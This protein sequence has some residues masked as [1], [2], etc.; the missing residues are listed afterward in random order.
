MDSEIAV[1]EAEFVELGS[2]RAA[3]PQDVVQRA[4]IIAKELKR[5]VDQCHLTSK[6]S[7]K[8]F[9]RVEAWTTVGAMIGVLPREVST[10]RHDD[11]G[12]EATVEL[13]RASDGAVIGRGSAIVGMD[14]RT[15]ASR[16]EYARRS[17]AI[18][19]ATG[20]AYRLGFSWIM[21]LA[22]YEPTPAE[23]MSDEQPA[24]KANPPAQKQEQPAAQ[25]K[26]AV[27]RPG[28]ADQVRAGLRQRA[29]W[30]K[31]Q[32][33]NWS[34][35]T[36]PPADQQRPPA[37]DDVQRLAA[38]M[39]KGGLDEDQRHSVN[40][41]L[42]GHRSTTELTAAEVEAALKAWEATDTLPDGSTR[43]LKFHA[44]EFA[45][46][47]LAACLYAALEAAGQQKLDI[48]AETKE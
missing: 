27:T 10:I 23:E 16:P 15:W 6:I 1:V 7:G 28:T 42:W 45:T 12:Y 41:W 29:G 17:M 18:T 24:P 21:T 30:V 22:G 37:D 19:R 11:G 3:G 4:T 14:E 20:K 2:V 47:E 5:I 32:H 9:P 26:P 8:E 38:V 39:G 13:V 33:L 35:A 31:G 40:L 36:R 46:P 48:P 25:P 34:D 44:N 43:P